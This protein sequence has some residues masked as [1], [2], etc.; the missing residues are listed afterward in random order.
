MSPP[1]SHSET[2]GTEP[3]PGREA[4]SRYA[5]L[6]I[7][8]QEHHFTPPVLD[9]GYYSTRL[10]IAAPVTG[11]GWLAYL[12]NELISMV[13]EQCTMET[14]LNVV[15][16]N[17]GALEFVRT[18]P[19]FDRVLAT[20]LVHIDAMKISPSSLKD[21]L[22]TM[23]GRTYGHL[24]VLARARECH[25]CG[26]A[27]VGIPLRLSPNSV[28]VCQQC[29]DELGENPIMDWD[30]YNNHMTERK[31]AQRIQDRITA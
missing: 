16:V 31:R 4:L 5:R 15:L 27:L 14:L 20:L 22:E 2:Q 23:K 19:G 24:S 6:V 13:L 30:D 28:L 3:M 12:P 25:M 7:Y 11:W 10:Q 29:N 8:A 9:H 17:R 21:F 18:L 1:I 26:C